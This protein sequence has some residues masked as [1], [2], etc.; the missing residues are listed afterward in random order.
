MPSNNLSA[1]MLRHLL[2]S[3]PVWPT[4]LIEGRPY[5][6]TIDNVTLMVVFSSDG[7]GWVTTSCLPTDPERAFSTDNPRLWRALFVLAHAIE[8]DQRDGVIITYSDAERAPEELARLLL[9]DDC[10]LP[11]LASG[12]TT[13]ER[14]HDDCDDYP[15]ERLAVSITDNHAEV[16]TFTDRGNL[17]RFRTPGGGGL[18]PR[19][20]FA[21]RTLALVIKH[22]NPGTDRLTQ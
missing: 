15:E 17:L 1:Q 20:S 2:T 19:T 10:Q 12:T 9:A 11:A 16:Q 5:S 13:V 8:A 18:S 3:V 4:R 22:E 7:D 6:I 21:L 14:T